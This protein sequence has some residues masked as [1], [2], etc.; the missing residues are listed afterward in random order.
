LGRA[1]GNSAAQTVLVQRRI[2]LDAKPL[3]KLAQLLDGLACQLLAPGRS[4]HDSKTFLR[5]AI[6]RQNQQRQP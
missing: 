1:L 6:V 3:G 5:L 2:T 4:A